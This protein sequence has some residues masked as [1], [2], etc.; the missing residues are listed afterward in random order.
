MA[1]IPWA[2]QLA[3]LD[4]SLAALLDDLEERF[5]RRRAG[6]GHGRISPFHPANQQ[7]RRP[8]LPRRGQ[9]AAGR[10][11]HPAG[12]GH[13]CNRPLWRLPDLTPVDAGRCGCVDLPCSRH[14]PASDLFPPP[15]P[16]ANRRRQSDRRTVCLVWNSRQFFSTG[17]H[18]P[19]GNGGRCGIVHRRRCWQRKGPGG[20]RSRCRGRQ[21]RLERLQPRHWLG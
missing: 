17:G 18:E 7:G 14:R 13:R 15:A 9:C 12:R 2:G 16:H 8:S 6:G 4:M 11:G 10:S 20:N 5:A 3:R 1:F 21:R 19:I